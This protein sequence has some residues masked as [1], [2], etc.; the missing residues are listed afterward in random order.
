MAGEAN[1]DGPRGGDR[2]GVAIAAAM[3]L[4]PAW[5]LIADALEPALESGRIDGRT[6]ERATGVPADVAKAALGVAE[7]AGLIKMADQD[8]VLTGA[9]RR[10]VKERG[11]VRWAGAYTK[12]L[13]A[14]HRLPVRSAAGRDLRAGVDVA[15]GSAEIGAIDVDPFFEAVIAKRRFETVIDIGGG[16]GTMLIRLVGAQRGRRGIG[17]DIDAGACEAAK[18]NVQKAAL[19]RQISIIHADAIR[20]A[21]HVAVAAD[22]VIA[23][24]VLHD[25]VAANRRA[26]SEAGRLIRPSGRIVIAEVEPYVPGS[27]SLFAAGFSLIH[28]LKGQQLWS[29]AVWTDL[30]ERA[31]LSVVEVVDTRLPNAFVLE[32]VR[33]KE[34]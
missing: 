20:A 27:R 13:K 15:R 5:H 2:R 6:V 25:L 1:N 29:K 4:G 21:E 18:Q 23:R 31:G 32:A 33:Q 10:A 17:I 22:L 28:A 8:I 30:L 3:M 16:C 34:K 14:A 26:V 9:G 7:A 24:F 11:Y 19:D 12:L